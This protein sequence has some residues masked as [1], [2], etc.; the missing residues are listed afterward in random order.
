MNKKRKYCLWKERKKD[1][2]TPVNSA[3]TAEITLPCREVP[4]KPWNY[5]ISNFRDKIYN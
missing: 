5:K 2:I 3:A 1:K 4:S